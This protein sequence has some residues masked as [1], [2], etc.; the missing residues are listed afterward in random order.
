[1]R[2][3]W[4]AAALLFFLFLVTAVGF[5]CAQRRII[6]G[7]QVRIPVTIR[8][9]PCVESSVRGLLRFVVPGGMGAYREVEPAYYVL[10]TNTSVQIEFTASPVVYEN[11]YHTLD[12][13]FWV[14]SRENTFTNIQPLI[15]RLNDAQL[16][17]SQIFGQVTIHSVEA[18]PAGVYHGTITITVSP[19]IEG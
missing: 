10:E 17:E 6:I 14:N 4:W 7:R 8:I 16:F 9:L 1:M 13:V 2:T 18:Q 11:A 5:A 12:V 15:L 3:K 19:L